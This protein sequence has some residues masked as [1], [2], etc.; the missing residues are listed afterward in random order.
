MYKVCEICGRM[1]IAGYGYSLALNW[2][3]TGHATIPAFLCGEQPGGQHWGCTA[4][5]AEQAVIQ[6]LQS[7]MSAKALLEKHAQEAAQGR[8]RYAE[9]DAHWAA[10]RGDEFHIV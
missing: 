8:A 3:V 1:F 4:E 10:S 5:H 6:C 9:E 7:H 2:L